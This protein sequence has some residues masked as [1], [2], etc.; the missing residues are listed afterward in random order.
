MIP[1]GTAAAKFT[2][3]FRDTFCYTDSSDTARLGAYDV[4]LRPVAPVDPPLQD[5]L[6]DLSGLART[7]RRHT[8]GYVVLVDVC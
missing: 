1:N 3:F 6:W 8:D 7:R 5:E 4:A 2:S